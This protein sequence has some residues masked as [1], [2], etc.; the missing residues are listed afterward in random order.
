MAD[1]FT[2]LLSQIVDAK[3][4]LLAVI[5]GV[6]IFVLYFYKNERSNDIGW[7]R[8]IFY[9]TLIGV[10]IVFFILIWIPIPLSSW[11]LKMRG[12]Q[13]LSTELIFW[14]ILISSFLL[15][16]G[17]FSLRQQNNG[18]PLYSSD[19]RNYWIDFFKKYNL[20]YFLG[21]IIFLLLTL[22]WIK[23]LYPMS[24]FLFLNWFDFFI[25]LGM[26]TIF[27][28]I[29]LPTLLS[30]LS[31]LLE[32][33]FHSFSMFCEELNNLRKK[34]FPKIVAFIIILTLSSFLMVYCDSKIGIITPKIT[35]QESIETIDDCLYFWRNSDNSTTLLA[36]NYFSLYFKSPVFSEVGINELKIIN[37]S[38]YT[39]SISYYKNS[40]S[41]SDGLLCELNAD[42]NSINIKIIDSTEQEHNFMFNYYS[43]IS[44]NSILTYSEEKF[45]QPQEFENGTFLREYTFDFSNKSPYFIELEEVYLVR[46]LNNIIRFNATISDY[47]NCSCRINELNGDFILDGHVQPETS[48]QVS[49][50]IIYT[51]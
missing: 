31:F 2:D 14:S 19:V 47:T 49:L 43:N 4:L 42:K 40:I 39:K 9:G 30:V 35:M 7:S 20:K 6:L 11:F 28:F 12:T 22:I 5:F 29:L 48:F 37:P 25:I 13:L 38:N 21:F 34:S 10:I 36:S 51:Y 18:K 41:S 3:L 24:Y 26:S 15:L 45:L 8:E 46:E 33:E 1:I 23:Y 27:L 32:W 44:L 17:L 50:K 16:L